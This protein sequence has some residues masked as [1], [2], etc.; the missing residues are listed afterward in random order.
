MDSRKEKESKQ[1]FINSVNV[2]REEHDLLISG[3][4]K[5]AAFL[6]G[7]I[8]KNERNSACI[9][10]IDGYYGTNWELIK[11]QLESSLLK[12]E[13]DTVFFNVEECLLEEDI[14]NEMLDPYLDD[15]DPVFG[16]IYH[17]RLK[18]FYDLNKLKQIREKVINLKKNP[19]RL[20]ESRE[21]FK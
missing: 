10:G 3:W 7:E 6:T 8:I 21:S 17:G 14:L 16:K 12:E 2:Q 1:Y 19:F 11:R 9:V 4:Q 18:D 15:G 20:D 5:M 13:I